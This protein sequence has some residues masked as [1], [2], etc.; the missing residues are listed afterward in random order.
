MSDWDVAVV[1]GGIGGLT[2]AQTAAVHG[3]RTVVFDRFAP[4]GQLMNVGEVVCYPGLPAKTTGAD[5]AASLIEASMSNGV[6]I[7][8]AEVTELCAGA[9]PTLQTTSGSVSASTVV[10]A[11]GLTAGSLGLPGAETWVGRGVSE[12][13]SC[14]GPLYTGRDVIVLGDDEWAAREAI[15]LGAMAV[16]VTVLVPGQPKWSRGTGVL[17]RESAAVR[18]GVQVAELVGQSAIEEV[19]LSDGDR[20]RTSGVFVYTGKAPQTA[21]LDGVVARSSDGYLT[22][23]PATTL[24]GVFA[25]GDARAGTMPSLLEAA[26]TGMWAGQAA[27]A[28]L[29]S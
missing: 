16:G 29:D 11:T 10:V 20:L 13:A 18:T 1:G 2:A 5:F 24:D 28:F 15:A 19:V 21:F 14:D 26:T 25:A 4:G 6:E 27:A 9:S 22:G 12:C 7:A 23:F 17:L 8:Y 3:L